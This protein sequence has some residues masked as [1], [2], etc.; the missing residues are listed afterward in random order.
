MR[1]RNAAAPLL[2]GLVTGER[3]VAPKQRGGD[4]LAA[5]GARRTVGRCETGTVRI[6]TYERHG[7]SQFAGRR[8][9]VR[10][11]RHGYVQTASARSG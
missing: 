9:I 5:L 2:R 6:S 11:L 1:R 10:R 3:Q 7:E 4:L 8:L